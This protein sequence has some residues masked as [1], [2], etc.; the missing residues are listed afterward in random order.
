M[1]CYRRVATTLYV[2]QCGEH[3]RLSMD[4]RNELL[5]GPTNVVLEPSSMLTTGVDNR[6]PRHFFTG[7]EK[8]YVF[9]YT[10][11]GCE[12]KPGLKVWVLVV[13]LR[14]YRETY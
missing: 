9:I 8:H 4:D 13:E 6:R 14:H 2:H 3:S 12:C 1:C 7:G 5:D 10:H 11:G